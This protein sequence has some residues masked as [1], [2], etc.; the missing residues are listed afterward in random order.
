MEAFVA[1]NEIALGAILNWSDV[2][3]S[4]F[5][6]VKSQF[7]CSV[8]EHVELVSKDIFQVSRFWPLDRPGMPQLNRSRPD[9]SDGLFPSQ[10]SNLRYDMPRVSVSVNCVMLFNYG[11]L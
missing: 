1:V 11:D 7:S 6:L 4:L 2:K 8:P 5:A 9:S 10:S 3:I